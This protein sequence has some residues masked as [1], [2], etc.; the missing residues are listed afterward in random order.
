[1]QVLQTSENN[2]ISKYNAEVFY[3]AVV[4]NESLGLDALGGRAEAVLECSLD[5]AHMAHAASTSGLATDGLHA[6]VI[7]TQNRECKNTNAYDD[8]R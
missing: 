4:T 1:M 3:V 2:K 8:L 5:T 6:P 7:C